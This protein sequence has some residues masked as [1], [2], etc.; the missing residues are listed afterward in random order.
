MN[1]G[2]KIRILRKERN[3]TQEQLANSLNISPQAVSKWEMSISYPDV[4]MLPVLA[5]L[6]N[7]S[8]DELFDYDASNIDKEIA[9]IIQTHKIYFWNNFKKA[10][11][12]LLDGLKL[13]P[14]SILLKTELFQLYYDH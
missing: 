13:Y 10:E 8:L 9:Q 2:N 14:N 3:L 6:Y 12:I 5:R 11:Q 1:L 4:E 7:I